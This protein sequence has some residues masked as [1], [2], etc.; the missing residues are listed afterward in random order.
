M[1]IKVKTA[2]IS[3]GLNALTA[4]L[5]FVLFAITGS[6][7]IL[8]DAWHSISDIGTS[9]IVLISVWGGTSEALEETTAEHKS[10]RSDSDSS[11]ET[12]DWRNWKKDTR[13]FLRKTTAEQYAA[14]A[15]G[16]FLTIVSISLLWR[17]YSGARQTIDKP[18]LSGCI[19][20]FFAIGSYFVYR[21]EVAVGKRTGSVGLV[22][23]GLHSKADMIGTVLTGMSLIVYSL[24]IDV[25]RP[26]ALL[27]ALFVLGFG[28]ESLVMALMSRLSSH[29]R[30]L[31][32]FRTVELLAFAFDKQAVKHFLV[33]SESLI[34]IK[35]L[36]PAQRARRFFL[37]MRWPA[38][39][40]ALAGYF[41]TCLYTVGPTEQAV[42]LR[43]GRPAN[44]GQAALPGLHLKLPWPIDKPVKVNAF[45]TRRRTIG[46][47]VDEQ[48]FALL[49]TQ[50]HGNEEPFLSGDNS[51]FF[52]Y[53]IVHYR[54]SDIF[55]F[56][57]LHSNPEELLDAVT[58][59]SATEMFAGTPFEVIVGQGRAE[60]EAE[61]G[62]ELQTRLNELETGIE[63]LGVHFR[64]MH[65]P[66]SIA[67]SFERVIAARQEKER[68]ID[69]AYG[70]RNQQLPE[71][72]GAAARAVEQ[73]TAYANQRIQQAEG[74]TGRFTA[75]IISGEPARS[76]TVRRLYLDSLTQ[77]MTEAS[78]ILV[79]P[80]AG[81]PNVL[82]NPGRLAIQR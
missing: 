29:N 44:I 65:P 77:A 20:L 19:F 41:S 61:I 78:I 4:L 32:H 70:Y 43:F 18:L 24:G 82:L 5:K 17:V 55:Q 56:V 33:K 53:L 25:D 34:G 50:A 54:I 71:K 39:A 16:I 51:F 7:A 15:I 13:E 10:D 28:I 46:N 75:R 52:P 40:L 64:D 38:L 45:S 11:D 3:T 60:L 47:I 80:T 1:D 59:N 67:D 6:L 23:D 68:I 62:Q 49:W 30:E 58:L 79:D 35:L 48:A 57:M 22:S 36:H 69:E 8:A 9:L 37:Q 27:I 81:T 74:D 26:V 2:L 42:L 66:I 31:T 21:F 63:I 14:F 73:A 12:K 76:L 72:R